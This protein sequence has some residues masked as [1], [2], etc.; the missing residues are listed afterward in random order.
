M[1]EAV[2]FDADALLAAAQQGVESN[3]AEGWVRGINSA[4]I[5]AQ[6]KTYQNQLESHIKN[7]NNGQS[8]VGDV[9]GEK[10]AKIDPLPYLAGTLPYAIRA[11]SQQFSEIPD[12]QRAKFKY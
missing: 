11:R 1:Q 5:E 3:E 8:T 7:Q 6:L 2:P 10:T 9:L 12:R 4:A